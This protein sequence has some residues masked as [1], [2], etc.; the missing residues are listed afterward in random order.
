MGLLGRLFGSTP[1][2][3]ALQQAMNQE[4]YADACYLADEL[5]QQ[6]LPGDESEMVS[7][8][9]RKAGDSLAHLNLTEAVA[10]QQIGDHAQADVHFELALEQVFSQELKRDIEQARQLKV[11]AVL[12]APEPAA[13]GCAGCASGAASPDAVAAIPQEDEI[14]LEL[15]LTSYPQEVRAS[16]AGKSENFLQAFLQAHDGQDEEALARFAQL[17]ESERDFC[18]WFEVGSLYARGQHYARAEDALKRALPGHPQPTLPLEALVDALLHNGQPAAAQDIIEGHLA[19]G[20][21]EAFCQ[22]QLALIAAHRQEWEEA[23]LRVRKALSG[24]YAPAAFV[25]LAASVFERAK[26]PEEAEKL[27]KMLPSGGCKST[28]HP[29]LAEFYLRH[30]RE[31]EKV[32]ACF[33][34]VAK[35]EPDNPRWQLRLAQSCLDR[36]WVKE[37][38]ALLQQLK[39]VPDLPHALHEEIKSSSER[40][41]ISL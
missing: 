20:S 41:N 23:V 35:R 21:A 24:G 39:Q 40:Y 19:T 22:A 8:M 32:F 11:S 9:R 29:L 2:V 36:G 4:R 38:T 1:T 12:P 7:D 28:M 30:G 31:A 5:L 15:I 10:C 26:A 17:D 3:T 25:P 37:G 6:S 33:N 13:S 16:Y 14:R 34:A 18:Y 27:L